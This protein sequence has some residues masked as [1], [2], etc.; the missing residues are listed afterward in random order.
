MLTL[1]WPDPTNA[2]WAELLGEH[3]DLSSVVECV[4]SSLSCRCF[5]SS[6]LYASDALYN[7]VKSIVWSLALL[8][9]GQQEG[10]LFSKRSKAAWILNLQYESIRIQEWEIG[11]KRVLGG[12]VIHNVFSRL[13]SLTLAFVAGNLQTNGKFEKNFTVSKLRP[14]P[15]GIFYRNT[16]TCFKLI[17]GH[18]PLTQLWQATP[19]KAS[20]LMVQECCW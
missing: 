18:V 10:P 19:L 11:W 6:M 2:W 3:K 20:H 16:R 4:R 5:H 15:R 9:E 1:T 12:G 14:T 8:L 13:L 7:P 17:S